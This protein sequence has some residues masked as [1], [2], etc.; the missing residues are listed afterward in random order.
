MPIGKAD[1]TTHFQY[2]RQGTAV[3]DDLARNA[4]ARNVNW[5]CGLAQLLHDLPRDRDHGIAVG[6]KQR[7]DRPR[8]Q[9]GNV[10]SASTVPEPPL[11][12]TKKR[13]E[14]ITYG[15]APGLFAC[16]SGMSSQQDP[17]APAFRPKAGELFP[18]QQTTAA[19]GCLASFAV[20]EPA[21]RGMFGYEQS[22]WHHARF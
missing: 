10:S 3:C 12:G 6:V 18:R 1:A 13:R 11:A 19:R 16:P 7:A 2:S 17:L 14:R 20:A 22:I 8:G 5:S 9:K 15:D 21:F 4:L